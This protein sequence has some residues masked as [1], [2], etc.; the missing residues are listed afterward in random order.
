MNH[1][2]DGAL[3]V[4]G[5]ILA[6]AAMAVAGW[7]AWRTWHALRHTRAGW[8]LWRQVVGRRWTTRR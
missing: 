7:V 4:A 5:A 2:A 1:L 3:F 6:I 8:W